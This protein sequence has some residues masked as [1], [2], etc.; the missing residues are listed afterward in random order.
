MKVKKVVLRAVFVFFV[1]VIAVK[2]STIYAQC[3]NLFLSDL[4]NPFCMYSRFIKSTHSNP[5]SLEYN[6]DKKLLEIAAK[7]NPQDLYNSHTN[8]E[9]CPDRTTNRV[10]HWISDLDHVLQVIRQA[11]V[12]SEPFK[13]TTY[14]CDI[15]P[16]DL[17]KD[18][19]EYYLALQKSMKVNNFTYSVGG[20]PCRFYGHCGAGVSNNDGCHI[21]FDLNNVLKLRKYQ[22][23]SED[24]AK[25]V[26]T[27]NRVLNVL[28]SD[29]LADLLWEKLDVLEKRE[30]RQIRVINKLPT[31]RID[32]IH[33]DSP[34]TTATFVF[35]FPSK[36][37]EVFEYGTCFY[38]PKPEFA[39]SIFNPSN[40]SHKVRFFP[41]SA[42]MFRTV[43]GEIGGKY[44][45]NH[46]K[47]S[48]AFGKQI[49]KLYRNKNI[50][51]PSWH[52]TP[53]MTY[54]SECEVKWRRTLFL[55]FSCTG[56][57]WEKWKE[58]RKV[59]FK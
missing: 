48:S 17:Y 9:S 15:W 59:V 54:N 4:L 41:N 58:G 34:Y 40:C 1:M 38:S 45:Y 24:F 33:S 19:M 49:R 21:E 53:S 23:E 57:C 27:W 16:P 39:N 20:A 32:T 28:K 51:F 3:T 46:K 8:Y 12:L 44:Y 31:A 50:S 2:M 43:P 29:T 42:F 36:L 14:M 56:S 13:F 22:H 47:K 26:S 37:D 55:T 52:A 10:S 5:S 6:F 25:M 18:M 30:T 7:A 11:P 35:M